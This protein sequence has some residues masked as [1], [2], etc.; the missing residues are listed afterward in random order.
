MWKLFPSSSVKDRH[1]LIYCAGLF[2]YLSDRVCQRLLELFYSWVN[3]GGLVIGT[4]VKHSKPIL[5]FMEFLFEWHLIYRDES[6][7]LKLV[8]DLGIQ[9]IIEDDTGINVFLKIRKF[10]I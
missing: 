8:P 5:Y 2:D 1:D 7:M 9:E 3:P 4:N 6:D 10:G